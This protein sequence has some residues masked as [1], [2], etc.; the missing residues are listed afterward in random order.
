MVGGAQCGAVVSG[1]GICPLRPS[2][3]LRPVATDDTSNSTFL[4][5]GQFPG[6][7]LLY[8]A[9]PPSG[10]FT[11]PPRPGVGRNSL[12]GPG[13]FSVDMTLVKRFGLPVMPVLGENGGIEL[14]AN[15]Y[16]VFNR[17]NLAPFN[18]RDREDNTQIQH[19]DFGRAIRV[20][21]GRVVEFQARFSFD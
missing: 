9:P 19:P 7:G 16:N 4:G 14:R 2:A 12:R 15:A 3:Q 11:T 20:L 10:S 17:T 8:F 6:G 13:Y 1:G 18:W 5:A 21:S